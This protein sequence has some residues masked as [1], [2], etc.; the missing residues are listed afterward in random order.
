MFQMASNQ[1]SSL[2]LKTQVQATVSQVR[3]MGDVATSLMLLVA[4]LLRLPI[5]VCQMATLLLALPFVGAHAFTGLLD[6]TAGKIDS[7]VDARLG[8]SAKPKPVVLSRP[9]VSIGH[10]PSGA[11]PIRQGA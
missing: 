1:S 3:R 7:A 4:G 10:A 6:R 9:A 2:L 5:L 8:R 11:G